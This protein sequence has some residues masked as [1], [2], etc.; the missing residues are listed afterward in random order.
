L[1]NDLLVHD[2]VDELHL[3][4]FPLIAGSG[5]PLFVDRPPVSLKLISTRTWQGSGNFLV[6]YAV[7]RK[8][9]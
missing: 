7:S 3:T 4:Y 6:C 8:Q 2:L 1:W 5:T 9:S